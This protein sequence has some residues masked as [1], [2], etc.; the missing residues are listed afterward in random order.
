MGLSGMILRK[1]ND[2]EIESAKNKIVDILNFLNYSYSISYETKIDKHYVLGV[3][4]F[5]GSDKGFVMYIYD[6]PRFDDGDFEWICKEVD[7]VALIEDIYCCGDM[8]LKILYEYFKDN[9][10]D[11]FYDDFKW[12]YTKEDIDKIYNSSDWEDWCYKKPPNAKQG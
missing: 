2:I 8:I 6:K 11:F 1:I 12:F 3:N 5:L 9:P 4:E 7:V 10:S